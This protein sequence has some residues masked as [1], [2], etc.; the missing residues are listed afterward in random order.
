MTQKSNNLWIN[1][2]LTMEKE[3]YNTNFAAVDTTTAKVQTAAVKIQAANDRSNALSKISRENA[4]A[5]LEATKEHAKLVSE[6]LSDHIEEKYTKKAVVTFRKSEN[7]DSNEIDRLNTSSERTNPSKKN[8]TNN[9]FFAENS[10][11][12]QQKPLSANPNSKSIDFYNG[13]EGKRLK[14]SMLSEEYSIASKSMLEK[15]NEWIGL[16]SMTITLRGKEQELAEK[17]YNKAHAEYEELKAISDKAWNAYNDALLET[18]EEEE[19]ASKTAW[20]NYKKS[21]SNKQGKQKPQAKIIK[22]TFN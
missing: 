6:I 15:M 9:I 1:M 21:I 20:C 18:N 16:S 11:L 10:V 3:E 4:T 22:M 13:V 8:S 19:K 7:R 17:E 2:N 5:L 12:D 14:Q